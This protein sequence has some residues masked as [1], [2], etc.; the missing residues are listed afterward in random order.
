MRLEIL[1]LIYRVVQKRKP[2]Q[3]SIN[4]SYIISYY[5]PAMSVAY[6]FVRW[7]CQS[8][9]TFPSP[10]IVET[11]YCD[12]AGGPR[13]YHFPTYAVQA[14]VLQP[15]RTAGNRKY[16]VANTVNEPYWPQSKRKPSATCRK[17][18]AALRRRKYLQ[19]RR[20][21]RLKP[22]AW[23]N[24]TKNYTCLDANQLIDIIF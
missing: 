10:I 17:T 3:R 11:C 19:K 18:T 20:E 23:E 24:G 13:L 8:N 9:T 22:H 6:F 4:K 14:A 1:R 7:K 5:N 21:S 16:T 2:P 15:Q 12:G